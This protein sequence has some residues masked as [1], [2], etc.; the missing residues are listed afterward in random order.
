MKPNKIE[1]DST[2]IKQLN[3]EDRLQMKFQSSKMDEISYK[4]TRVRVK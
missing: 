4:R 3:P 1:L 2:I